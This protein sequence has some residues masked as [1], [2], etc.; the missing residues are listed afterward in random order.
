MKITTGTKIFITLM[1]TAS[2]LYVF[3]PGTRVNEKQNY[4]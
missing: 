2:L 1:P 4:A 3:L